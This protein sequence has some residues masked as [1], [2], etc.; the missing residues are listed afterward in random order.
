VCR[1]ETDSYRVELSPSLIR[2][3][4]GTRA[5]S[6]EQSATIRGCQAQTQEKFQRTDLMSMIDGRTGTNT[7]GVKTVQ[8]NAI[9]V[10]IAYSMRK[11]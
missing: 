10:G 8:S 11:R 9:T 4:A 5:R 2:R 3:V 1:C 7:L 6:T